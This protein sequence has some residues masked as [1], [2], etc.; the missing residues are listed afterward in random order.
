[1]CTTGSALFF[2]TLVLTTGFG[3][4]GSLGSLKNTVYFGYLSAL[5]IALAFVANMLLTPA[6]ISL[7]TRLEKR[8]RSGG[9]DGV[10]L[11]T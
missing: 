5:G 2:T 7:A 11:L 9:G 6:L 10:D 3:V 4:M 1:M 8:S